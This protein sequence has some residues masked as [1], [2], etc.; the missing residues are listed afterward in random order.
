MDEWAECEAPV[1]HPIDQTSSLIATVAAHGSRTPRPYRRWVCYCIL[2]AGAACTVTIS[3]L[4]CERMVMR[5]A[6]Q[7]QGVA[8]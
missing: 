4:A 5:K 1:T 6:W 2:V 3:Q 7:G 8:G